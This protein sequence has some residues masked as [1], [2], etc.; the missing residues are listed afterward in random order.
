MKKRSRI[1]AFVRQKFLVGF[2][3]SMLNHVSVTVTNAQILAGDPVELVAAT[4]VLNYAGIPTK[5]FVP[6]L[7]TAVVN[8]PVGYTGGAATDEFLLAWGS[9]WSLDVLVARPKLNAGIAYRRFNDI[10]LKSAI[11]VG[12]GGNHDHTIQR[13]NDI[14]SL[15]GSMQDNALMF[16]IN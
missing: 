14:D 13:T 1:G 8:I 15:D 11:A 4:E 5:L 9:D 16:V 6:V 7:A 10:A 3:D 2:G 12:S